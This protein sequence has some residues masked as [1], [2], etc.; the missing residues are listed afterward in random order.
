MRPTAAEALQHP[1]EV[2]ILFLDHGRFFTII[3]K[4]SR[5]MLPQSQCADAPRSRSAITTPVRSQSVTTTL[6]RSRTVTNDLPGY[7]SERFEDSLPIPGLSLVPST[8]PAASPG[9]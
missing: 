6:I 2:A 9:V 1:S 7:D 3:L 5:F 4:L 8:E